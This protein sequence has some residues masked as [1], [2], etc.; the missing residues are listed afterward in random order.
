MGGDEHSNEFTKHMDCDMFTLPRWRL[1][2][3]LV[4]RSSARGLSANIDE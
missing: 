3:I 1:S 2:A 4:F